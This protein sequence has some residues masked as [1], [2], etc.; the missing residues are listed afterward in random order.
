[1]ATPSSQ[2]DQLIATTFEN[3]RPA[4]ADNITVDLP[5]LAFLNSKGKVNVDG[6]RNIVR[7]LMYALNSTVQ[8]FSGY[9]Q[10]DTTAQGG[11][12]EAVYGWRNLVGTVTI[13]GDEIRKNS[14]KSAFISLMAS[15][16]EQLRL[17]IDD[18]FNAQLHGDGTGNSNKDFL[19]LRA[20][21]SASGILG[22]IDPSDAPFWKARV[23]A[24]PVDLT[25]ETGVDALNHMFNSLA[26]QKS[27]PDLEL[28]TQ[29]NFEAYESLASEK[30]RYTSM[31]M[32]DLG[33]EAL[34]HKTAEVV[35]DAD[36]Y[37]DG[38]A[39]DGG[40]WY[41]LNSQFLEFVQHSDCWLSPTEFVRPYNQDAKVMSVLSSG[42]L[43]TSNRRAQGV[44][45]NTVVIA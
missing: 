2:L 15:K 14:G 36:T 11:I 10:F 28:T 4:L 39:N 32:A 18:E 42:N 24:G 37:S 34:A 17:S 41:F 38:S 16:A 9:D 20:I 40:Y 6:G 8:S 30:V 13:S 31:K 44:I 3:V 27:R 1:M 21:V 43:I 25:V 23:E 22:G 45:T 19:G 35:F 33:F 7:P 29:A 26:I 12:G 5:L